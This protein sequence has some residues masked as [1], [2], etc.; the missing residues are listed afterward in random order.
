[1]KKQ[2]SQLAVDLENALKGVEDREKLE[3]IRVEYLGR[4]GKLADLMKEMKS[5]SDAERKDA[6]KEANQAKQQTTTW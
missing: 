5:L 2:F 3:Q 1:M 6:G 4:K